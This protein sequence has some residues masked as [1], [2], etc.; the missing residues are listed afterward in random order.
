MGRKK[1]YGVQHPHHSFNNTMEHM[2][3]VRVP[4]LGEIEKKEVG[5][6]KVPK[7]P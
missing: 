6:R 2:T 5:S 1:H 7:V 4:G 3:G